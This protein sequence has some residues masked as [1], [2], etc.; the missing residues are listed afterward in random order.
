MFI[1]SV[2]IRRTALLGA[3][4]I[5]CM[6]GLAFAGGGGAGVGPTA[7][8][9]I[10]VIDPDAQANGG[11]STIQYGAPP[12]SDKATAARTCQDLTPGSHVV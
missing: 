1:S 6:P 9:L 12:H 10:K 7:A 4:F 8:K 11:V 2:M 3:V 5:A